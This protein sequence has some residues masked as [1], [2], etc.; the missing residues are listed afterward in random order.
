M[1]EIHRR[2]IPAA[3]E[4]ANAFT[5]SWTILTA[6]EAGESG[7]AADQDNAVD[8]A[9]GQSERRYQVLLTQTKKLCKFPICFCLMRSKRS[10][11]S[12]DC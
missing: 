9:V 4:D 8:V 6:K 1:A 10:P 12:V 11:M 2:R 7:G 3:D 5:R